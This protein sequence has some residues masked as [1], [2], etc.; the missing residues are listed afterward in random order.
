MLC[1][2]F[3]FVGV[4]ACC[5][6][7]L[8]LPLAAG[9]ADC[10]ARV[11]VVPWMWSNGTVGENVGRLC[12]RTCVAASNP[13]ANLIRVGSLNAVPKKLMPRGIPKVMPAGTCTIGYPGGAARP[14]VPKMK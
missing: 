11:S 8:L 12:A 3:L 6:A 14:D 7:F 9:T 4:V 13:E 10:L 2:T 5:G 1:G